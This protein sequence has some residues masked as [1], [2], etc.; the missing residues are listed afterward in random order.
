MITIRFSVDAD[1]ITFSKGA[2]VVEDEELLSNAAK[3]SVTL[4]KK[5]VETIAIKRKIMNKDDA[6]IA[7]FN[8]LHHYL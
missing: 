1:G 7:T 4:A 3:M 8:L 2:E 6:K 5:C